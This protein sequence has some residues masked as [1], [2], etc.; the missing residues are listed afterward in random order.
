MALYTISDLHLPLGVD[1]PMD[2]FGPAWENYVYRLE[3][4]WNAHIKEADCVVIPGDFSWAMR[5]EE[6]K[7]DFEFI[8]RLP[9]TK[10][11]LKGNHDYWWD[12]LSK[13]ERFASENAFDNI[14]FL[15]NNAFLYNGTAICGTRFWT[16]PGSNP[17]TAEDEK[18]YLRELGRA[19]LSL[20]CAKKQNPDD[21]IFFT[22]YPPVSGNQLPDTEFMTLMKRY[23]VK[24]VVYG[25]VHGNAKYCAFTGEYEGIVFDLVSCDYLQFMPM[26]LED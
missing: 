18:I 23:D 12:T 8:C 26:K 4:N 19:Q 1:K 2:I 14:R 21:A 5:L 20:Q 16:C 11:L 24:R 9:G 3:N 22:H 10:I 17:F 13:L 7:R 15:Q 25:H 6:T